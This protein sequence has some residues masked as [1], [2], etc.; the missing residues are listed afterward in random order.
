MKK[1]KTITFMIVAAILLLV[2]V[3]NKDLLLRI[4]TG[5]V[6]PDDTFISPD[7]GRIECGPVEEAYTGEMDFS[8]EKYNQ[9]LKI[10]CG[11]DNFFTGEDCRIKLRMEITS[12]LVEDRATVWK[13][14]A[15]ESFD[16]CK[17]RI[18]YLARKCS[19]DDSG[20]W[21]GTE[22]INE[23]DLGY[24]KT[25]EV[26]YVEL[27]DRINVFYKEN[28][29]DI[30]L[31]Y[32]RWG[33]NWYI[34][35]AR[36]TDVGT[37]TISSSAAKSRICTAGDTN[38]VPCPNTLQM[39]GDEGVRWCNFVTDWNYGPAFSVFDHPQKGEVYCAGNMIYSI[40]RFTFADGH[41]EKVDPQ[42]TLGEYLG[43]VDCCPSMSGCNAD[44]VYDGSS[45]QTCF[46]DAQ[47]ANGGA[48]V[49]IGVGKIQAERCVAGECTLTSIRTVECTYDA[50]C[51]SGE[52]CDRLTWSCEGDD[53]VDYCG[54]GKCNSLTEDQNTCPID[55]GTP[56]VPPKDYTFIIISGFVV[57]GL[58]LYYMSTQNKG[59][60]RK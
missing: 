27:V 19:M 43:T 49:P 42:Y 7:W 8:V 32:K 21:Y 18:T 6:F 55:C 15:G 25:T 12:D 52:H 17:S 13:C 2:A 34:E 56:N 53:V 28:T 38:C 51:N 9:P 57:L 37:C 46:S 58:I 50:Q 54:D 11:A 39:I 26:L 31:E 20:L 36:K 23:F 16:A 41:S 40:Q 5:A 4:G 48:Y 30:R 45:G 33:L 22:K 59:G 24:M 10:E 44:F 35:G 1:N 47:C 14:N 29:A 60:K 3:S